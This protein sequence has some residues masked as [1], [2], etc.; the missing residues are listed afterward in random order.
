MMSPHERLALH[1][2]D[3]IMRARA[4]IAALRRG[5]DYSRHLNDLERSVT[6]YD[7]MRKV[8]GSSMGREARQ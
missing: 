2:Q 7:D 4:L 8:P 3:V 1:R 6:L 5:T